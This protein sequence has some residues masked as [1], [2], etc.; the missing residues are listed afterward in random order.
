MRSVSEV[1]WPRWTPTDV[2]VLLFVIQGGRALLIHKKRGLGAGKINAPGG[3][4]EPGETPE[5]AAVRETREEVGVNAL[6]PRR[7]GRLRF[8][9]VDGYALDCHV[10]SSDRCEGEPYETDE[11]VPMWTALDALPYDRMWADDRMWL[12]LML[13]GRPFSGHFVFDGD[14]MVDHV[15]ED[16]DPARPLFEKLR[17][18]D[19]DAEVASHPP[20]FTVEQARRHRPPGEA[21]ACVKN[22]FVRNKRGEAWLVTTLEDRPIDLKTLGRRIGAGHLSFA[23]FDRLRQQLGV[24]PGSVTPLAV[25]NDP[26]RSV[27]VVLDAAILRSDTVHVHP[28]TNDRTLTLS[29]KDLLRFLEAAGHPPTVLDLEAE[30]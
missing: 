28:L 13:A 21:G 12:P 27:R 9:F 25:L 16:E 11:A 18:L 4:I 15:L 6:S 22:L 3:R 24:E 19:I 10:L 2:A 30:L 29:T 26:D 7:R 23:S 5:Q 20:V 1:D 17:E 8:Q 14:R